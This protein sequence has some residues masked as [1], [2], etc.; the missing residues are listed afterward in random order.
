MPEAV[1]S[2][3]ARPRVLVVTAWYPTPERPGL[4]VF[5]REHARAISR[6]AD[7]A[8]VHL[9]LDHPAS[10]GRV[11][12]AAVD[13]E[14]PVLRVRVR[15]RRGLRVLDQQKGLR[16]AMA[17][18]AQQ[19][20]TPDLLHAHV[21]SAGF[22]AVRAA[23]RLRVPC[24]VT[25]HYSGLA[26]GEVHGLDLRIARWTFRRADLV[27]PVSGDLAHR[28]AALG[29]GARIE[30]V[31]NAVDMTLFQP[32]EGSRPPGPIR[33]L[34]VAT[35][36]AVKGVTTLLDALALP[37]GGLAGMQLDVVGG[38][39]LLEPLQAR[40]A[41]LGISDRVRWRG[42]LGAEAVAASMRN[43]DVFVLPSDWENLPCVLLEAMASGLP[44]VATRVGGVPEIVDETIG[45]LTEPGDAPG[46]ARAIAV[47]A[48][49]LDAFDALELH[50][51]AAARY[52]LPVVAARWSVIYGELLGRSAPATAVAAARGSDAPAR[53]A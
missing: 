47:V 30:A 2:G 1:S 4:G 20:F 48:T 37:D 11:E 21:F 34:L 14:M 43:A 26:R 45:E 32:A 23:R 17:R 50:E 52:G 39:P 28:I 8:V 51:R 41:Q 12:L 38:G 22:V 24:V 19:G 46:L 5:V 49:R 31:P 27:A 25:E 10:S 18:L 3:R 35:L 29:T 9:D 7:V 53:S 36:T 6:V 44:I 16:H 15:P 13:D 33:L 40:A 42:R